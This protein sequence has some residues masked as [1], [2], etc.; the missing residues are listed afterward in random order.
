MTDNRSDQPL[1]SCVIGTKNSSPTLGLCLESIK[2]Q[3]YPNIEIIVVDNSSDDDTMEIAARY[4]NNVVTKG[5][6][7][8]W[9]FNHGISI[10]QGACIQMLASDAEMTPEVVEQC[11]AQYVAGHDMV[12]IPERHVGEG[13]WSRAKALERECYLGD[14]TVEAPWFFS[15]HAIDAIGGYNTE[16]IAGEDWD[17]F[18]R[19]KA[20]GFTYTRCEAF[21][22]HHLG[23]LEFVGM[24]RKKY[25]YGN[26]LRAYTQRHTKSAIRKIPLFRLAYLRNWKKLAAHPVLAVGMLTMKVA[27]CAAVSLSYLLS[28]GGRGVANPYEQ[29]S[30]D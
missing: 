30:S 19:M 11:V 13:F 9:Q 18:E 20:R 17:I 25:Y 3:T 10:A 5:P 23:R 27:E 22:H 16:I 29:P 12:I 28:A 14:D 1:V 4:T 7:R 15:K 6:E 24:V 26:T 2:H 8:S 21:I